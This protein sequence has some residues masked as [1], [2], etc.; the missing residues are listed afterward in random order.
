[1]RPLA[2]LLCLA[3]GGCIP[4]P[5]LLHVHCTAPTMDDAGTCEAPQLQD[6][7]SEYVLV[8]FEAFGFGQ[9]G[10]IPVRIKQSFKARKGARVDFVRMVP[11]GSYI[12]RAWSWDTGG[13]SCTTT[14]IVRVSGE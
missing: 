5:G 9:S 7:P 10:P 14:V 8:H 4:P 6:N 12:V 2:L 3:V 11:A 1:M 13:A